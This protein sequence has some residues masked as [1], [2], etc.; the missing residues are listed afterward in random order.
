MGLPSSYVGEH[1][2]VAYYVEAT[3]KRSWK[4]DHVLKE[5]FTVNAMVD[6]N[7]DPSALEPTERRASKNFC[8]LC[9]ASGPVG[10]VIKLPRRGFVP[11][12]HVSPEVEMTNQ[13]GRGIS[14]V[15]LSLIQV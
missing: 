15:S 6:L 14:G 5:K 10:F 7:K 4:F 9:C 11:G 12:E 3:I 2:Q 13:S 8:C 1:G